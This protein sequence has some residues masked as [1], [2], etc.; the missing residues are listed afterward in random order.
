MATQTKKTSA[1]ACDD[2]C[3]AGII[4]KAERGFATFI[5]SFR[6]LFPPDQYN[7]D[8]KVLVLFTF[9]RIKLR[10]VEFKNILKALIQKT[11]K[12]FQMRIVQPLVW[13]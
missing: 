2:T 12:Y 3:I 10:G 7:I 13:L 6:T 5:P 1:S 9:V 8:T 4:S 11:S